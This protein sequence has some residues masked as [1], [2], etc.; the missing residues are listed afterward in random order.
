MWLRF[1]KPFLD[2]QSLA[3]ACAMVAWVRKETDPLWANDLPVEVKKPMQKSLKFLQK[4]GDSFLQTESRSLLSQSQARWQELA[5]SKSVSTQVIAVRHLELGEELSPDLEERVLQNLRSGNRAVILHT[6]AATERMAARNEQVVEELR[7]LV[8]N[9]DDEIR[10]KAM[11]SLARMRS[12]D[13]HSVRLAAR[14]LDSSVK[15]VAFA[16]LFALSSLDS[17][18]DQVVAAANRGF[19]KALQTCNYEFVGLY[20]SAFNRWLDDPQAHFQ[21][22]LAQDSPEYLQI[23]IESLATVRDQL[24]SLGKVG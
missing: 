22:L 2:G 15:H 24:V 12:V 17:V 14:M 6:I 20:A 13:E 1:P 10:A 18:S 21:R 5:A 4:S 16:G 9:R 8:E 23:A 7:S 11:C 3:Y 19:L